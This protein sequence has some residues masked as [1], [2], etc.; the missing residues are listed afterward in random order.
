MPTWKI[1]QKNK[2]PKLKNALFIE[3]L[4]GIGN[5]GKVAIDFMIDEIKAVKVYEITS[6]SF[7]HSV[8]VNDKNLVELPTV[9]IY[10][11]KVKGRDLLLMSG[12]VQPIDEKGCY[13]FSN[14]V[15]DLMQKHYV[16][17]TITLGGI[18]LSEIP[19]KPKVYMA[20]NSQKIASQYQKN[21]RGIVEKSLYGVVGPIVGVSGL[22]V[23]LA[24]QRKIDAVCLLSETY[25]HPMYLGIKGARELLR[26]LEKKLSLKINLKKLEREIKE[27]EAEVKKTEVQDTSK[28]GTYVK[29]GSTEVNYIG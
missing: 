3:G 26:A 14:D 16:T 2:V 28:T 10:Y 12:D 11:K 27:I 17:E 24:S 22:L 9:E 5:V 13:E 6:F 1:V 8:F 23:G 19:K 25:G 18:G 21:L 4:P 7:P 15:L 29:G 20:G